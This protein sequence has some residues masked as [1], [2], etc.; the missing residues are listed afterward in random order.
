MINLM[1]FT[2]LDFQPM[3]RL[4]AG[5]QAK[6]TFSNGW[7]I[8][9]ITGHS[10]MYTSPESPYEVAVIRPTGEFLD[11][12]VF[13]SQTKEEVDVLLKMVGSIPT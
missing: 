1:K 7:S 3:A 2:D 8:S 13:G 11:D 6:H 4:A 10:C 5:Q 12:D 9:I